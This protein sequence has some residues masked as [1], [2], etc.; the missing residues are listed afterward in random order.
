MER[1]KKER[2]PLSIFARSI[3]MVSSSQKCMYRSR[4]KKCPS[5]KRGR[6]SHVVINESA[7][8]RLAATGIELRKGTP[9][10]ITQRVITRDVQ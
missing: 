3:P 5:N 7:Q 6:H 10:T 1:K 8:T 9:H 2:H 4:L